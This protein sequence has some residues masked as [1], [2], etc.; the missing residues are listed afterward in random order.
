MGV[1]VNTARG[2]EPLKTLLLR[3]RQPFGQCSNVH[4]FDSE[5]IVR[6]E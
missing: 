1:Q 6:P 5:M 4:A 2:G 3:I